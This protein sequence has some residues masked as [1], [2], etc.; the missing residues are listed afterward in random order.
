MSNES[1]K[2]IPKYSTKQW[3]N[4]SGFVLSLE[5][6]DSLR[7]IVHHFVAWLRNSQISLGFKSSVSRSIEIKPQWYVFCAIFIG[8]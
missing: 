7:Y 4:L 1:N 5:L 3:E 8:D 6:A 2:C